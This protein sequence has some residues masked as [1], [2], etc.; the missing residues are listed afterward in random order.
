MEKDNYRKIPIRDSHMHVWREQSMEET[1]AFHKWI[2]EEFG[3]E[4][5]AIMSIHDNPNGGAMRDENLKSMYLKKVLSPRVYAYAGL[6]YKD[7]P[8]DDDGTYFLEQAKYYHACG[9]DGIKMFY[10]I[11]CYRKGFPYIPLADPRYDKYF[12]FMEE[13]GMPITIHL[14]GPEACFGNIEDVPE[15][16]R[17]WHV[18]DCPVHLHDMFRDFTSMMDKFPKLKIVVAHFAFITWHPDWAQQWLDKYENLSFDLTPS[19]FMYFDF[20]DKPEIWREFLTRNADRIIYGTDIGSNTKDVEKKEPHA[21]VHV[22]RGFFEE[23]EKIYEFEEE[24]TPMPMPDDILKKFYKENIMRYYGGEPKA[25][26]YKLMLQEIELIAKEEGLSELAKENL[27][28]MRKE[29][30]R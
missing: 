2:L 10:P 24:F 12:A 18:K 1:V 11:G 15:S 9:Y 17:K 26:N 27:E 3:Y 6:H 23:T 8:V 5:I 29:F 14:G 25:A 20:Q 22:V 28:V 16:Q 13:T 7:F 21:L 19:L 30:I 4:T